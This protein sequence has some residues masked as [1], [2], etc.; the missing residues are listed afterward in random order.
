MDYDKFMQESLRLNILLILQDIPQGSTTDAII[1]SMAYKLYGHDKNM[2]RLRNNLN[3]LNERSLI[4]VDIIS[5]D[6]FK[7]SITKLGE[8]VAKGIE[9][10]PEIKKT[11]RK[12]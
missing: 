7:A 2:P 6:C 10:F 3:W 5:A 8:R 11:D 12:G 9:Y 1:E 4:I